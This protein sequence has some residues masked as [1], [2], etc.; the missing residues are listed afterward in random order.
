MQGPWSTL[1]ILDDV[2]CLDTTYESRGYGRPFSQFL[3]VNNHKQTVVFG[4]ALL[5]HEMKDSFEWLFETF[6]TTISVKKTNVI[7]EEA[8][9]TCCNVREEAKYACCHEASK[10]C[11]SRFSNIRKPPRTVALSPPNQADIRSPRWRFPRAR[12][13]PRSGANMGP[14]YKTSSARRIHCSPASLSGR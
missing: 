7:S 13:C 14:I 1:N 10:S 3:G 9:W 8:K 12:S 6:R 11:I 2:Q 5:Y 4:V